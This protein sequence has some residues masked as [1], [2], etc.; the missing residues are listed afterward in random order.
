MGVER[1]FS[2]LKR[3]YNFIHNIDKKLESEHLLID[4]N[5]IVHITSQFL[6][7]QNKYSD[8]ETF[9]ADLINLVGGYIIKL[10]QDN[11]DVDKILS[12]TI[13][14]DGVPSM[15]KIFEQKKRRYMGDILSHFMSTNE[16]GFH[17]SKNN[18][19]PGTE[20]MNNMNNF[21]ISSKFE[22]KIRYYCINL[23]HYNVSGVNIMGEGEMKIIHFIQKMSQTKYKNDNYTVYSPDSDMIIILLMTN[24]NVNILRYDQQLSSSELPV[25]DLIDINHFKNI[26]Y[27]YVNSKLTKDINKEK[28]IMDLVFMLTV[29]GDDFLPKLETVRVNTDINLLMDHYILTLIKYGYLLN[30]N[31]YNY[32]IN[33][34]N[35]LSFLT[36]LQKKEEY[37]LRR[38]ARY[39]VSSNYNKIVKDIIGYQMNQLREYIVEYI[40]KFI[41]FNKP[42][43]IKISP[44]NAHEHISIDSLVEFMN[45]IEPNMNVSKFTKKN[46]NNNI[47]WDKMYKIISDYYIEI[48]QYIDGF[49]LKKSNIYTNEVFYVEALPTQLLKDIIMYFFIN[50]ELPITIPLKDSH[51]NIQFHNYESTKIPHIKRLSNI[52]SQEKELYLIDNKLD[53]YYK[54]LNP[55]DKFYYDIYFK[56][57]INYNNYYNINFPHNYNLTNKLV[58]DYLLGLN[59]IYN[60]YIN[61][62]EKYKMVDLSWYYYH[63]RSP[64]LRD[65]VNNYNSKILVF[66]FINNFNGIKYMTPLEHYMYVTPFDKN[67]NIEEKLIKSLGYLSSNKIK[68]LALFVKKYNKY[69]YDLDKIYKS[70]KD[71]RQID[72]SS[73]IF[74]S[75]CHLLF[76]ETPINLIEYL[77]NFRKLI[78]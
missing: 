40:W 8:K 11:F 39:H 25:Y 12:I 66:K 55:R 29:F 75:K 44:I 47:L 57:Q 13:C 6:N 14:I 56:N 76:L 35:L 58:D 78:I 69:Y 32:N 49:K 4:F 60:Y 45:N 30:N 61:T 54:I 74:I 18:I 38:N 15:S 2:S 19:S 42:E 20:F 67:A 65:I 62:D 68:M 64:L 1:F 22:E 46:Y 63:N 27:D 7:S 50:Y 36:L 73:S 5:S 28:V 17:W 71:E 34:E 48:L 23:K 37:F 43:H 51:I 10:L 26:L 9:E 21:L 77:I 31:N 3:D 53:K 70:L 52:K 33:T 72:C 41:Y 16:S 24:I 59:W